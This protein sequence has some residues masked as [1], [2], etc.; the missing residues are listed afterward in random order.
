VWDAGIWDAAHWG[1]ISPVQLSMQNT[2]WQSIGMS[3][4]AHAPIL[5]VHIGQQAKP[6]IEL[7]AIATTQEGGGVN[8]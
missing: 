6:N 1:D 2:M 4:F 3:G 7:V 8:V 5:Q